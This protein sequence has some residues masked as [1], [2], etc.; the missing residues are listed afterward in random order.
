MSS[1]RSAVPLRQ[2][3]SGC[4]G[5]RP[6]FRPRIGAPSRLTGR[7]NE[8]GNHERLQFATRRPTP[9]QGV[10]R[11][12]PDGGRRNGAAGV[13]VPAPSVRDVARPMPGLRGAAPAPEC[14]DGRRL[15][16]Q[17]RARHQPRF[18][19]K[20]NLYLRRMRPRRNWVHSRRSHSRKRV[21]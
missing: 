8:R 11:V 10:R 7:T 6:A 17:Q 15:S 1:V 2:C 18:G 21:M 20:G 9:S 14:D 4:I 16:V 19:G 3:L 5:I 12:R 13:L